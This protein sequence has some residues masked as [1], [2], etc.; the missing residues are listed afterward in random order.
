MFDTLVDSILSQDP[1]FLGMM[2]LIIV[3]AGLFLVLPYFAIMTAIIMQ[4]C[5]N[6]WNDLFGEGKEM[7]V[8]GP[9]ARTATRSGLRRMAAKVEPPESATPPAQLELAEQAANS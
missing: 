9:E 5:R 1:L 2:A 8:G 6:A 4:M 7:V 3:L